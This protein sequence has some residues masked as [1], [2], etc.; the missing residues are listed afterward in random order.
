MPLWYAPPCVEPWTGGDNGGATA[1]GVTADEIVVARLPGPARPARADVLRAQ[2]QRREPRTA[3]S[4]P[5]SSTSTSSQAHYET[6]G[7]K[8]RLVTVKASGAARR[9]RRRQGRRHQGRDRDQGVRVVRRT[10]ARRPCTPTSSRRAA[11]SASATAR[12][13]RPQSFLRTALAVR[14]ADARVTRP[15]RASTGPRSSARSSTG[16]EARYAG[17]AALRD[18]QRRVRRRALR[19]RAPARSTRASP[20]FSDLLARPGRRPR[21]AGPVPARPRVG[22]GGRARGDRGVARGGRHERDPRRRPGVPPF[23]TQEATAQGYFPEWVV[24]GYAFTD[25][26]VFGRQYD[27]QQWAHAFGVSLLPTRTGR[28]RRRAGNRS[29]SGR[30]GSRPIAKTFRLLVQAPLLFF[31]GVHLAGPDLTARLVPRRAVPLPRRPG[32]RTPTAPPPLVGSPR[33]LAGRRPHRRRRRGRRSG[34]TPTRTGP[35]EVGNDGDRAVAVRRRGARATSPASGP[36]ATSGSTTTRRRSRSSTELPPGRRPPD[37]PSPAACR[38]PADPLVDTHPLAVDVAAD[39]A[40]GVADRDAEVGERARHDRSGTDDDVPTDRR[41][42]AA[43]SSRARATSRRRSSPVA[44]AR[45]AGR[46]A[47]STSS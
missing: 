12:S 15:G 18:E 6:Y 1:P 47:W 34:G 17:D 22:A 41:H 16:D 11:C 30:R 10:R 8:V 46:A 33:H 38:S 2:R 42:P 4:R 29:S 7:R 20:G 26:A 45:T 24:L 31:T 9:R 14:L 44:T 19:R 27:Q 5:P 40:R 36:T 21:D 35:D 13:P 3:S 39:D 43:R 32:R 28:R 23:L 37:Y 25:T